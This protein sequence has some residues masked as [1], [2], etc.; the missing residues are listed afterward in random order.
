M[1]TIHKQIFE[2]LDL[3]MNQ[4]GDECDKLREVNDFVNIDKAMM[5]R[6]DLCMELASVKMFIAD[7][8]CEDEP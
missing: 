3:R 8:I 1:M 2:Y 7:L 6:A 5:F 4:I